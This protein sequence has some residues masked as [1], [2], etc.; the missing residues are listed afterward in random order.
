MSSNDALGEFTRQGDH[1][2]VHFERFYPRPVNTVWSA[3]TQPERLADWM[4]AAYVE[5]RVGGRF[6]LMVG[7]PH[8][9]TGRVRVWDPP[10][11]LEFSW[12]NTHAPDSVV[13][14]ELQ[15]Q[16]EGTRLIFTHQGMPYVNSALMLPGWHDFLE[17]LGSALL[18]ANPRVDPD[19]WQKRQAIY[20]DHY[21]L[22][23]VRLTP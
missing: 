15:R 22:N 7:G 12:S 3:L 20:V 5:P 2:D 8:P 10:K 11:V 16:G 19:G 4:G 14:Y 21:G 9:M 1:I 13:R 6:E 23:D 17:H 18:E